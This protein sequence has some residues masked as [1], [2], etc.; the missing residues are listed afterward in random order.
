MILYSL[1]SVP[2]FV[3][4]SLKSP[5]YAVNLFQLYRNAV[6]CIKRSRVLVKGVSISYLTGCLPTVIKEVDKSTHNVSEME[7]GKK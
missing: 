7:I 2:P 5:K 3:Y 6:N 1:T 4:N